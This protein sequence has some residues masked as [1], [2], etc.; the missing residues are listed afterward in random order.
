MGFLAA[1]VTYLTRA[2]HH[3]DGLQLCP[4]FGGL[5]QMFGYGMQR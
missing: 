2:S 1:L 5:L 4:V 3:G